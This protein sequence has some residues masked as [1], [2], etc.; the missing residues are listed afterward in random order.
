ME[1]APKCRTH[2]TSKLN[3]T[4]EIIFNGTT[5]P[6]I[7]QEQFLANERNKVRFSDLL[8]KFPEKANVTV[9]QAAENA[10][11]LIVETAV[12][13]IS[14]YD[15]IFVVG[16]NIDF[17]VLLTGLAPMKENLY[18]RKCGKGRTPDVI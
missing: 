3:S 15:N 10:D 1:R 6:E 13:V 7:S 4:H 5:C 16:E 17:L 8:K 9:K 12:S 2:S 14:Q 11:V 18:F